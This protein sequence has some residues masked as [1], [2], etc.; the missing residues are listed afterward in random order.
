MCVVDHDPSVVAASQGD[1]RVEPAL[2][3]VHAERA[4]ADDQLAT[5]PA[6]YAIQLALE[7][8]VS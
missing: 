6:G 7:M 4:I 1:H 8:L 2:V 5:A 3:A